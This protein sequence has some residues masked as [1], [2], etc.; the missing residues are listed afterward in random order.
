M[1]DLDSALNQLP[2]IAILRGLEPEQALNVGHVLIDAGFKVIEVPLN[3]PRP[4]ESIELL[5]EAFGKR[6]LIGAGTVLKAND[7]GDVAKAG[8]RLVV[9][10]HADI[11]FIRKTDHLGL[12]C[13]PGVATPTE[14]FAAL[15]SGA[16]CLKM[17]PA[18]AMPPAVVKAWR[19]VLRPPVK[20]LPVG[21]ITA[22][23]MAPYLAA[24]ASGFGLG[25]ALFKPGMPLETI[26]DN[27]K[28]FVQSC[29]S[30]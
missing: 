15:E 22:D 1:L 9:M 29:R 30:T 3:S 7:I 14:A 4:L 17:F 6:A 2:L 26:A 28:T 20:L 13:I 19:A 24:G 16:D 25:S 12:F 11:S 8:G 21:G 23:K 5:A 27:A 10:P 18:E